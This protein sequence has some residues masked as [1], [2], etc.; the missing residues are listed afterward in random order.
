MRLFA[1]SDSLLMSKML[2]IQDLGLW[3][4]TYKMSSA[5][6]FLAIALSSSVYP[7]F[8]SLYESD[9]KRLA[10]LFEKSYRYLLFVSLPITA[11]IFVLADPV[12]KAVY[13]SAYVGSILPLKIL[14][15]S[16]TFTFL[17]YINGAL[18]NAVNKQKTQTTL[19]AIALV[20]SI[21]INILLIPVIGIVG[22]ATAAVLS[23]IWLT[24]TGYYFC[25]RVIKI[26]HITVMKYFYQ[27][28]FPALIMAI[29]VHYLAKYINF[30]YTIPI[31]A[32]VYLFFVN[33][34]GGLSKETI[35]RTKNK[36][37][38]KI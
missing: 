24:K 36:L 27:T 18:L 11:G 9:K 33:L 22:A 5:F 38:K 8:S 1:Y 28:F 4:V 20:I 16:I 29:C 34:T 32:I 35:I 26:R 13:G 3:S 30:A 10:P 23:S 37:F 7:V 25:S 19:L 21:F 6:Y 31:G 15:I 2:S 17:S 14:I 12:I